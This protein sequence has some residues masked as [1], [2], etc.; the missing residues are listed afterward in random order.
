MAAQHA[1]GDRILFQRLDRAVVIRAFAVA[2][3]D[4]LARAQ[5]QHTPRV[6]RVLAP[7]DQHTVLRLPVHKESWH[8]DKMNLSYSNKKTAVLQVN[9]L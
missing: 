8:D 6:V 7:Q 9:I 1:A 4:C 2:Q 3:R 5:P